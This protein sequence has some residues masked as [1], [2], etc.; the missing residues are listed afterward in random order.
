MVGKWF[1][2]VIN[3]TPEQEY[4]QQRRNRERQR[5]QSPQQ[6]FYALALTFD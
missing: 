2:L 3:F 5:N 1:A 4:E 6:D